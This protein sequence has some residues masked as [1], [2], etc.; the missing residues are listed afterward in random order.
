M[1]KRKR[2]WLCATKMNTGKTADISIR[3]NTRDLP[4]GA[5][6]IQ[7]GEERD[8]RLVT[9]LDE[10]ESERVIVESNSL[11]GLNDWGKDGSSGN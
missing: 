3:T 6:C 4:F 11:E 10:Q 7:H 8:E 5:L 2:S 9:C 1:P